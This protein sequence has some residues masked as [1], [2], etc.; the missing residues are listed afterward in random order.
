[1]ILLYFEIL[2]GGSRIY[3]LFRTRPLNYMRLHVPVITGSDLLLA[4]H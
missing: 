3:A 2:D 1:M 4:G